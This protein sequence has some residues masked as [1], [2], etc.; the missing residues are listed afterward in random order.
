MK[1]G[2]AILKPLLAETGAPRVGKIVIG[3][4]KGDIHDIG[5][6]L[7]TMMMEGAG[8]EVKNIGINNPVENYLDAMVEFD[9]DILG[10]SALL[11]TTMPYM[12]VVIDEMVARGIRDDYVVMVGGAPLNEEFGKAIGADAYCRDAAVAVE[13]AKQYMTRRHNQ[14]SAG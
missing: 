12:K 2:M 4:V 10:M 8:F 5:Q 7:V 1:G 14:L 11:T 3:T 6:N 13:T 9:A